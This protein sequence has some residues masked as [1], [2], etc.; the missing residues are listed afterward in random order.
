MFHGSECDKL[1]VWHPTRGE[2]HIGSAAT[3][4]PPMSQPRSQRGKG[5][6]TDQAAKPPNERRQPRQT[7]MCWQSLIT[8]PAMQRHENAA[9]PAWEA[10]LRW[11][12]IEP[13]PPYI[14]KDRG[15]VHSVGRSSQTRQERHGLMKSHNRDHQCARV[16]QIAR[17]TMNIEKPTADQPFYITNIR[18]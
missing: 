14:R 3:A 17:I 9:R 7:P 11:T 13:R 15:E 16:E 8:P 4:Q 18:K 2:A 5:G 1:Y 10:W 6:A 12:V